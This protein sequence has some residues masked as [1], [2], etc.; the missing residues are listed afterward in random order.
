MHDIAANLARIRERI[1]T[2]AAQAGRNADDVKLI[3]VS[4]THSVDSIAAAIGAGQHLFGESTAQE[5]LKKIPLLPQPGI[6]WHFIG[7]LQSNK[8]KFIPGNFHWL[9]SLD[10][11]KLAQRLARLAP[12]QQAPLNAL[13]EINVTGDPAKHGIAPVALFPLLDRL[14]REGPSAIALRGLMTIAPHA[15]PASEIRAVFA[16]L[17]RLRDEVAARYA[18]PGFTELSMGMSDDF[19]DAIREGA[20]FVRVGTAIFGNRDY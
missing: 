9:H 6:E 16:T 10:D 8:V 15:A 20:T 13:I 11:V 3:A 14:L 1:A 17:R 5:A 12:P 2:A 4:K 18:L 19:E 7:H